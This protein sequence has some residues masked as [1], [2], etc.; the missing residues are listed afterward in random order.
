[1][2]FA[3]YSLSDFPVDIFSVQNA[4][5]YESSKISDFLCCSTYNSCSTNL[6]EDH[7]GPEE[8]M[9]LQMFSNQHCLIESFHVKEESTVTPFEI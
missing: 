2:S 5:L 3:F 4:C 7:R 6:K 9:Y 8:Q 1:M